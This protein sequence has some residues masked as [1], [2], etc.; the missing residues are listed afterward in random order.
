MGLCVFGVLAEGRD[1]SLYVGTKM[2]KMCHKKEATGNQYAKWQAAV[3]SKAYANLA[4]EE[5]RAVAEKV[6]VDDPQKSPKCLKC[7]STA[8]SFTESVVTAK[9]SV[10]DGVSCESCHGPGKKYKSK[11]VMQDRKLCIEKGMV[12]PATASC[13]LCHNDASPTWKADRYTDD[14]GVKVGF[15]VKKAYE[16]I[17]HPNPRAAE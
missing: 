7:H 9:V 10:E 16:K 6:G 11:T 3:H 14:D 2:C 5:A 12:Y 13:V 1:A 17:K 8:Y 15:D 4:S